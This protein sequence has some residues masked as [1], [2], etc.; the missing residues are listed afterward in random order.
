VPNAASV[1]SVACC[2]GVAVVPLSVEVAVS[3]EL[4]SDTYATAS[5]SA[6]FCAVAASAFVT[7]KVRT[8]RVR[9]DADHQVAEQ[10]ARILAEIAGGRSTTRPDWAISFS[11]PMSGGTGVVLGWIRASTTTMAS[12]RYVRG[13][14]MLIPTAAGDDHGGHQHDPEPVD[15]DHPRRVPGRHA[16][17]PFMPHTRVATPMIVR[18]PAP[19]PP[20]RS[21]HCR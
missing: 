18:R 17:S 19:A 7:V 2:V 3:P 8:F 6:Y 16:R 14:T 11:V 15:A 13:D 1:T 9:C 20:S 21:R 10:P 4:R 12:D 5:A